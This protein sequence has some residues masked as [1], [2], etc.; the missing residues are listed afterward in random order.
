M[1]KPMP[2]TKPQKPHTSASVPPIHALG[3]SSTLTLSKALNQP[4]GFGPDLTQ[5]TEETMSTNSNRRKNYVVALYHDYDDT[6]QEVTKP[7]TLTQA[8]RFVSAMGWTVGDT[9]KI[10]TLTESA[11][12]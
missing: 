7:L 8:I 9:V 3:I 2:H 12:L 6:W 10:V 1:S 4:W 11:T 5:P